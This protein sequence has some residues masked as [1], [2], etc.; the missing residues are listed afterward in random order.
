MKLCIQRVKE[1]IVSIDG[2]EFSRIGKGLLV[3]LGISDEDDESVSDYIIKKLYNLRIFED[4]NGKMNLSVKDVNGEL[5]IVSQFTKK[6]QDSSSFSKSAKFENAKKIY[7]DFISKCRMIDKV[8]I[9]TGE[10]GADMKISLINDGPVTIIL[11]N[12]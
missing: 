5:M 10:F 2:K 1:A 3:F 9:A 7:D 11:E 8:N 4:E 6:N 12:D